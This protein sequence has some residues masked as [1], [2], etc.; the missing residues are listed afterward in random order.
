MRTLTPGTRATLLLIASLGPTSIPVSLL[1]VGTRRGLSQQI[2]ALERRGLLQVS[3]GV[4]RLTPA[5]LA[6]VGRQR[7]EIEEAQA[8]CHAG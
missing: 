3:D 4:V 2:D 8:R 7:A 6:E 1:R 5:G